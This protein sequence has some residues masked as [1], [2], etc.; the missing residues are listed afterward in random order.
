[1][2][3]QPIFSLVILDLDRAK[4]FLPSCLHCA[5]MNL[6]FLLQKQGIVGLQ[7]VTESI[8]LNL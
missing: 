1:M 3:C 6:N 8:K 2:I 7:S 4:I 5:L